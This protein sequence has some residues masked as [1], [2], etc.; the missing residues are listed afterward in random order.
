MLPEEARW[1]GQHISSVEVNRLSPMLN[2]GSSTGRFVTRAQPWIDEFVFAPLRARGVQ[3][4]N[5]DLKAAPGVDLVGDLEDPRFLEEL[6]K[7]E[8][9]SLLCSHLLEHVRSPARI[10]RTLAGAVVPGGFLFVTGPYRY[11]FQAVKQT[12]PHLGKFEQA[13]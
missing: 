6:S 13:T 12:A 11:P 2:I 3:V 7:Q 8:L 4:L 10:A 5:S 9:K 1:L